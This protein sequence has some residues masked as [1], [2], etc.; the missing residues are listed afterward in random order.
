MP[1]PRVY[2]TEAIVL[3][4]QSLGEAD[5]IVTLLSPVAGKVRAVARSVRRPKSK[6]GGHL[7]LLNR[8]HVSIA[9]GRSLDHVTEADT[10]DSRLTL[11][12]DLE[13][14]SAGLYI[15]EAADAFS[16]E[17]T[18]SQEAYRLLALSLALLEAPAEQ[19]PLLRHFELR[20]LGISGFGPELYCCVYCRE[21][22][23]PVRHTFSHDDSGVVCSRCRHEAGGALTSL[24]VRSMKALRYLDRQPLAHILKLELAD[25]TWAEV[26][27][28]LGTQLRHVAE[29]DIRSADF[30]RRLSSAS[31]TAT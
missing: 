22:L 13:R 6:L 1:R 20:L 25:Q 16:V 2:K 24:S 31:G 5:R 15:A 28:V 8:V 21:D 3:R 30:M 19:A 27:R 7:E 29:R 11:K 26:G 18:P 12:S 4:Q 14:L 17:D 23:Q 9:E 10:L